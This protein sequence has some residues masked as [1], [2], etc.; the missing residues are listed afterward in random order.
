[1]VHDPQHSLDSLAL[2]SP[3][4]SLKPAPSAVILL[5]SRSS[6]FQGF[7]KDMSASEVT[8]LEAR[9]V[10]EAKVGPRCLEVMHDLGTR[11]LVEMFDMMLRW[12]VVAVVFGSSGP[13]GGREGVVVRRV[14]VV[15][16]RRGGRRR[17][18]DYYF[19]DTITST[20][21]PSNRIPG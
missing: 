20:S 17:F 15:A 9:E 4:Q 19:F 7:K 10:E 8:P 11:G 16:R 18:K 12:V 2:Q 13:A 3:S 14:V 6:S 5:V 21:L 1:M